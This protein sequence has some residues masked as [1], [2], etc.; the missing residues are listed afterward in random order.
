MSILQKRPKVRD[1]SVEIVESDTK[2]SLKAPDL[3]DVLRGVLVDLRNAWGMSTRQLAFRL[4]DNK[5]FRLFSIQKPT[6]ARGSRQ[7]ARSAAHST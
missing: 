1:Y 3:N 7:S 2:R 4:C 6:K 5:R